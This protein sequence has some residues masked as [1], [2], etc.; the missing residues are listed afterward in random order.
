MNFQCMS[1]L[2]PE[3][4]IE[5]IGARVHNLQNVSVTIPLHQW[6][7]LAGVSGSGKSS[8]AFDTLHAESQRRY[9][10]TLSTSAR[11]LIDQMERPDV[12]R[13]DN[14]PATIAIGLR[15]Q[16]RF[17]NTTLAQTA[18]LDEIII[19][20]LIDSGELQCPQCRIGVR[21]QYL[22]D[23][24]QQIS[25]FPEG[26]RFQ[27]CIPVNV[28]VKKADQLQAA[29]QEEKTFWENEGF[30]RF[31]DFSGK[32]S[33]SKK[34]ASFLVIV[35]RLK[36]EETENSRTAESVEQ[37][38]S[39]GQGRCLILAE[40]AIS[41]SPY[42]IPIADE[43]DREWHGYFFSSEPECPKCGTVYP[44]LEPQLFRSTSPVGACSE[45]SGRGIKV[46]NK[47]NALCEKCEGSGLSEVARLASFLPTESTTDSILTYAEIQQFTLQELNENLNRLDS[48]NSV[49]SQSLQTLL[50][51]RIDLLLELGLGSLQLKRLTRTLS[52]G[53]FQRVVLMSALNNDFVNTLYLFDEPTNGLHPA[54]RLPVVKFLRQLVVEGNTVLTIEHHSDIL[55]KADSVIELGPAAGKE[56]GTITYQGTVE[57][58][59]QQL[60][61]EFQEKVDSNNSDLSNDQ[62]DLL[63]LTDIHCHNLKGIDVQFPLKRLTVVT[64]VCG[65]GKSSLVCDTLYPVL[66][67]KIADR[68]DQKEAI[69]FEKD[70]FSPAGTVSSII[71]ADTIDECV[72]MNETQLTK[73]SRSTPATY[74][75]VFD[76]IRKLF[77]ETVDAQARGYT[78]S[79]FSFNSSRGGRCSHCEGLGFIEMDMQFLANLTLPC[80]ECHGTRFQ[81]ET[82][83]VS[84]RN[85][86]I[87]DVLS[88]T[89][90]E[91][92]AFF[93]NHQSILRKLQLLR[94]VG[95]GYLTLGQS[96]ATLSRG[97]SQRLKLASYLNATSGLHQLFLFDEPASGLHPRDIETLLQSLKRLVEQGHTVI[98]IEHDARIIQSA[99]WVIDLRIDSERGES[100]FVYSGSPSGLRD[101]KKSLTSRYLD[102]L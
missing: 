23:A 47:L 39:S 58:Y 15:N 51:K 13:I 14:L 8:L 102:H 27:V 26:M 56:G 31:L 20:L 77:A 2:S 16:P 21:P 30:H 65:S 82:L 4:A 49:T 61:K 78:P 93:R 81:P 32:T 46:T 1:E 41:G 48:L 45:C 22:A 83:K 84:Y 37:A 60:K 101:C 35:D 90:D 11:S 89:A 100:S 69:P 92:F 73:S 71:G 25:L 94:D 79:R 6:T 40:E 63:Q 57:P 33:K 75:K 38:L 18:E 3:K 52:Q 7:A 17:G 9:F 55:A 72:L 85:R 95:L 76:D 68:G 29:L 24:L 12:D 34:T 91:A 86:N 53:E 74:L 54:D 87:H 88:M 42:R 10:E 59:L 50:R 98:V 36:S 19:R 67:Q 28:K 5:I 43:R 62:P 66:T 80:P 44:E 99:D 96:T 97:E 70:P 64:G